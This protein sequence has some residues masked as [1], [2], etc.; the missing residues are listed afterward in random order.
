MNEKNIS[1]AQYR[2]GYGGAK[3]LGE[4][5]RKNEAGE[6]DV[7]LLVEDAY[8]FIRVV[9]D[10]DGKSCVVFS[11]WEDER[12]P[13]VRA[14]RFLAEGGFQ[15]AV[16]V[17]GRTYGEWFLEGERNE[18]RSAQE[19]VHPQFEDGKLYSELSPDERHAFFASLT[20][21]EMLALT[22]GGCDVVSEWCLLLAD[23]LSE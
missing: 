9:L 13:L 12:E 22:E 7:A 4:Y 19:H 2:Q 18:W 8:G 21:L 14:R 17:Q 3:V 20:L 6:L 10:F 11:P 16:R 23:S 5:N 15:E 1:Q